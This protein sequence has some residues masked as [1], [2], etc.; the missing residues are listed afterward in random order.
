MFRF[1]RIK[2]PN[3]Q[4]VSLCVHL[5]SKR[6]LNFSEEPLNVKVSLKFDWD[7][8]RW[9]EFSQRIRCTQRSRTLFLIEL[10]SLSILFGF[11]QMF[12][13]L[14]SCPISSLF[15]FTHWI[16]ISGDEGLIL[17]FQTLLFSTPTSN[18]FHCSLR[19]PRRKNV[20]PSGQNGSGLRMNPSPLLWGAKRL[21]EHIEES[22]GERQIFPFSFFN[23]ERSIKV[24][25]LFEKRE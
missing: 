7:E 5:F 22:V 12:S 24:R 20:L 3:K 4:H 21:S 11:A 2:E 16:I 9:R 25:N 23:E 10:R 19:F 8:I 6:R 18:T 13:P 1:S 17:F 14:L 15:Q